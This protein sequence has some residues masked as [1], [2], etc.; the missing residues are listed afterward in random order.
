MSFIK[1]LLVFLH[2]R[3]VVVSHYVGN[4]LLLTLFGWSHWHGS[5]ICIA[6]VATRLY[7][8]QLYHIHSVIYKLVWNNLGHNHRY[9]KSEHY[10][11]RKERDAYTC[12]VGFY[13][14]M[15][16]PLIVIEEMRQTV[17]QPKPITLNFSLPIFFYYHCYYWH[18]LAL[19]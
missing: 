8:I 4:R 16:A 12:D 1:W 15:W 13:F 18:A 10:G 17:Y 3:Q 5:N 7:F 11:A 19:V 2:T 9:A 6:T 14:K